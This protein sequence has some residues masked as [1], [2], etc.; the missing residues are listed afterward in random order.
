MLLFLCCLACVAERDDL[1][2]GQIRQAD[3]KF[4]TTSLVPFGDN[5]YAFLHLTYNASARLFTLYSN[6]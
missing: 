5:F 2:K 1:A 3:G 4:I 6:Q